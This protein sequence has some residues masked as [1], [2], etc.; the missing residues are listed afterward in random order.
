MQARIDANRQA[1]AEKNLTEEERKTLSSDADKYEAE[2]KK[3]V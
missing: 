3:T 2:L 1:L